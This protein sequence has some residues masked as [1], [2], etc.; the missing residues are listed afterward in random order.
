M[1]RSAAVIA[2]LA[3]PALWCS[4]SKAEAVR[5]LSEV[6]AATGG[7]K[8]DRIRTWHEKG[9]FQAG[10]LSGAHEAWLDFQRLRSFTDDSG[11]STI[12]G[13]IR[14]TNGWNGQIS[15]YADQSR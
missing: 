14:D 8:R 9:T 11:A 10:D 13:T 2:V 1:I 15:W 6:R 3:S 5:L 12:L 7:A 4:D